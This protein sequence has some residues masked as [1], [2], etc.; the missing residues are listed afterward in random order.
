[1]AQENVMGDKMFTLYIK[2]CDIVVSD[3]IFEA[4]LCGGRL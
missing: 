3:V 2:I 1:M 4:I